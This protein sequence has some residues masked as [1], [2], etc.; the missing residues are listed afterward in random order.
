MVVTVVVLIAGPIAPVDSG[1]FL[2]ASGVAGMPADADAVVETGNPNGGIMMDG[3]VGAELS[4]PA[5]GICL[6][7]F[8]IIGAA[9]T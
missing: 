7:E 9:M 4:M 5:V 6:L 8:G 1:E 2:P 3:T